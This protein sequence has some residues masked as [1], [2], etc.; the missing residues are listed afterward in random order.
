MNSSLHGVRGKALLPSRAF[1]QQSR[2]HARR[3]CQP[4][5]A[6]YNKQGKESLRVDGRV[7]RL[8]KVF[9]K[10]GS[11]YTDRLGVAIPIGDALDEV[12][13]PRQSLY[14]TLHRQI[15]IC[16]CLLSQH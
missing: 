13:F 15:L 6:S 3:S 14:R 2:L 12:K 11:G 4:V 9:F 10:P 16:F 8:W 5:Q 7:T 1:L